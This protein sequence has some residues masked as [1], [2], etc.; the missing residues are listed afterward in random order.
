MRIC[1]CDFGNE[2]LS[3]QCVVVGCR[4]DATGLVMGSQ[5]RFCRTI[6]GQPEPEDLRKFFR[7]LRRAQRDLDLRHDRYTHYYENGFPERF[8]L[9]QTRRHSPA[10]GW[11]SSR[12]R[13]KQRPALRLD[14]PPRHLHR[15]CHG[16]QPKWL[17]LGIP[18]LIRLQT[19]RSCNGWSIK[20]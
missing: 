5:T 3:Q 4:F 17:S 10:S 2:E 20:W 15:R 18:Q 19:E 8:S 1:Q 14:R 9:M 12:T 13:R 16:P 7:T 11:C 6:D